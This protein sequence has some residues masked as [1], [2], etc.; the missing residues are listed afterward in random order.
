VGG[1][2]F[3]QRRSVFRVVM[4]RSVVV[5]LAVGFS[6]CDAAVLVMRAAAEHQV[7]NQGQASEMGDDKTHNLIFGRRGVIVK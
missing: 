7:P 6:R 1:G 3:P 4:L 5:V 2:F